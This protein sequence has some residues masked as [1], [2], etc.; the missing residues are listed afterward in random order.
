MDASEQSALTLLSQQ[1]RPFFRDYA[2][3]CIFARLVIMGYA[4]CYVK[5]D[6]S[7]WVR[8]ATAEEQGL[9]MKYPAQEGNWVGKA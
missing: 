9:A 3:R 6:R 8:M 2:E 4:R 5:E 1:D 7:E